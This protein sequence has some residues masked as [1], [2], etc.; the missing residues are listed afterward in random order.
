MGRLRCG[1]VNT[2]S[3]EQLLIEALILGTL[4]GD[5][6]KLNIHKNGSF[7]ENTIRSI[8]ILQQPFYKLFVMCL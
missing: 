2:L 8:T 6:L 4:I 1:E 5:P 3:Y 7:H